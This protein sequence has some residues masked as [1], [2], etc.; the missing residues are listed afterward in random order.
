M[1][2]PELQ[3]KHFPK[4]QN[5][6]RSFAVKRYGLSQE[7]V[8]GRGKP[9]HRLAESFVD[10]Q[11]ESP[12]SAS[13]QDI[14]DQ[15]RVAEHGILYFSGHG[16]LTDLRGLRSGFGGAPVVNAA[17]GSFAGI[18]VRTACRSGNSIKLVSGTAWTLKEIQWNTVPN[19]VWVRRRSVIGQGELLNVD[20]LLG[21]LDSGHPDTRTLVLFAETLAFE[22]GQQ[23]RLLPHLVAFVEMHRGS[24]D[25]DDLVALGSAIRKLV[26]YLPPS[27]FDSLSDLLGSGAAETVANEAEL[28]LAKGLVYRL[29]WDDT[30]RP[31]C[32]RLC[33]DLFDLAMFHSS[34]RV[35]T[36]SSSAAIA[37]N[38]TIALAFLGDDRA[39]KTVGTLSRRSVLW[40][41]SLVTTR[42]RR[43]VSKWQ[44]DNRSPSALGLLPDLLDALT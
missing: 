23:T 37:L 40:F 20:S 29:T 25:A 33:D 35:V 44:N 24:S 14:T 3:W 30:A 13:V 15:V 2:T 1:T 42:V 31:K 19:Q 9:Q 34:K 26:A 28:E 4:P 41:A 11:A 39:I 21:M 27:A 22:D 38:A 8:L 36:S 6:R 12:P 16:N 32:P 10:V 17:D 18:V 43:L 5:R 7:V